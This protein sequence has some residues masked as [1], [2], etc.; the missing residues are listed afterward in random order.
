[1]FPAAAIFAWNDKVADS[2]APEA[3]QAAE[4]ILFDENSEFDTAVVIDDIGQAL[5]DS[6]KKSSIGSGSAFTRNL[7]KIAENRYDQYC[8]CRNVPA[9]VFLSIVQ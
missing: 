2:I 6:S 5:I 9:R 4:Q 3:L 8:D 1:M 7:E